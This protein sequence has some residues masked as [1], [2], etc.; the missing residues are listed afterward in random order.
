M[1]GCLRDHH[2]TG[3]NTGPRGKSGIDGIADALAALDGEISL[4]ADCGESAKQVVFGVL[5]GFGRNEFGRLVRFPDGG[6]T[7]H[8][9]MHVGIYQTWHDKM[10]REVDQLVVGTYGK[11]RLR[12]DFRDAVLFHD[13]GHIFSH[14]SVDGIEQFA[15]QHKLT[16]TAL[17][18]KRLVLKGFPEG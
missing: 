9:Q 17:L 2:A 5:E 13:N 7:A 1:P 8:P 12:C 10:A 14:T 4:I 16:H 11:A 15:T 6:K 18:G 3:E